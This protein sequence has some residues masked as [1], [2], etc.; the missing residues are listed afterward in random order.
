MSVKT[1]DGDSDDREDD[2]SIGSS[3]DD[4][5]VEPI[6]SLVAGKERR[7]T[8]GNRLSS[9]LRNE[10]DDELELLFAENE[11]EEDNEF[12]A[13]SDDDGSDA[14][15]DSSSDEEDQGYGKGDDELE[16][17]KELQQRERAEARKKRKAQGPLQRM[18]PAAKRV[19]QAPVSMNK[20]TSSISAPVTPGLRP[21][22]KSERASWLPTPDDGPV[23]SST[24]K[25]TIQNRVVV[26]ER[27][28][29]RETLRVKTLEVMTAAE[30]RK[31]EERQRPL[32]Q[33]ERL[34]EAA[35]Q[36]TRN[37]K[38]LNRWEASEK[39]KRAEQKAKLEALQNRKLEGP[40]ITWWSGLSRW[41]DGKVEEVGVKAIRK[42]EAADAAKKQLQ[43]NSP[44][45]L[46]SPGETLSGSAR[47]DG[48]AGDHSQA[49]F[50][51]PTLPQESLH[52]ASGVS[53]PPR[54][55]AANHESQGFLEGIHYY[56]SLQ[57][58]D[59]SPQTSTV[60]DQAIP[61]T[62]AFTPVKP[63][64]TVMIASRSLLILQNIDDNAQRLPEVQNLVMLKKRGIK[65]Q[66]PPMEL[67]SITAQP[68]KYRD[69]GTGLPY[70]DSYAYKEIQRL[71]KGGSI[72]S[73][74][75]GC[76]VGPNN[77]AARGVPER[78]IRSACR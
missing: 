11:A 45:Q 22:K 44:E 19:R 70:A 33:D 50:D 25:Q 37:A 28:K 62:P 68:A 57:S 76:Y 38:T 36:E 78:F 29:E 21:K 6:V 65:P 4:E 17:E 56:A 72:W 8:A 77:N 47:K 42:V 12:K 46:A 40:V 58:N 5:E 23:R 55:P 15:L 43:E 3:N 24:R 60:K 1:V 30:K 34:Q 35:K 20:A 18:A 69:P 13:E 9:L 52:S 66:R 61:Q 53:F 39:K 26:H 16:G 41:V 10:G 73:N 64:P 51:E 71:R 75:L 48:T 7:Q 14:R 31:K 27:M 49:V 59:K 67:C 2:S 74:L 54:L 63:T 32:T